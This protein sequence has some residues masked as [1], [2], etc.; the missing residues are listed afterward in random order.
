MNIMLVSVTER[1]RE[2]GIRRA[3]GA[4]R[5]D[6]L[7]QL[8]VETLIQCLLGGFLGIS[9]GFIAAT[10]IQYATPFPAAIR[11]W[12]ILLGIFISMTIGLVFGLYPARRGANLEPVEAIRME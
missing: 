2:I 10:I 6:I 9:F 4:R 8:L 11:L 7:R 3:L 1:T 5:S 12:V